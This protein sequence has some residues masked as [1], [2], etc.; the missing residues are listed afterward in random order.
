[1]ST[2]PPKADISETIKSSRSVIPDHTGCAPD[3]PNARL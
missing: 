3:A 1:M 2:L